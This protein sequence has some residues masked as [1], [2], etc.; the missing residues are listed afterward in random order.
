MAYFFIEF[1][2]FDASRNY[3]IRLSVSNF[4]TSACP[5][6]AAI[7]F[8]TVVHEQKVKYFI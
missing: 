6:K 1:G 5:S 2:E 8:Y 7:R 3:V 4:G